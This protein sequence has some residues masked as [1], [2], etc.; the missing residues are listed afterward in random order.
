MDSARD[1]YGLV[2]YKS[3]YARSCDGMTGGDVRTMTEF[4]EAC[5]CLETSALALAKAEDNETSESGGGSSKVGT[6]ALVDDNRRRLSKLYDSVIGFFR[7]GGDVTSS[8]QFK[9]RK[10]MDRLLRQ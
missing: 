9:M 3:G 4:F 6:T 10:S 2:L 8:N 5:L 1:A 7:D